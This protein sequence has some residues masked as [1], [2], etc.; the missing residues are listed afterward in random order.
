MTLSLLLPPPNRAVDV[1]AFGEN[2]L[3]FVVRAAGDA[4][5]AG[6]QSLA[7]FRLEPGGQMATAAL[8]CTRLGLRARYVGAFGDD[9]WARRARAPLDRAGIEVVAV[10]RTGTAGRV[11]VIV[12]DS[13]GERMVYERRDARLVF[14][15]DEVPVA[16]VATGRVLLVDATNPAASLRALAIAREAGVVSVSDVD[17]VTADALAL[18]AEVDVA[19]VPAP[20]V[21][22]W[23]GAA[24]LHDGLARMARH[25]RRAAVVIAT[26]GAD[27]CTAWCDGHTIAERPPSVTVVDTTGAGDAFRAGFAAAL[28]HMGPAAALGDL[29]RF[30]NAAGALNC[31]AAGAQAA[32]PT[33]DEVWSHV[34]FGSADLSK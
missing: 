9:E 13:T 24:D 8:A 27:G 7:D 23:T 19:V 4:P 10:E 31:R 17:R 22:G 14:D 33:L 6:K 20:F 29:L 26:Q 32:L 15:P 11:A 28:V 21:T 2:S 25:C 5:E 34:T 18:L 1:V 30:A 12:V 3:D 16:A